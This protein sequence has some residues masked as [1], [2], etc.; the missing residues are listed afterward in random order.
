MSSGK[1]QTIAISHVTSGSVFC[2]Y[3]MEGTSDAGSLG[4]RGWSGRH[5][6]KTSTLLLD[7]ARLTFIASRMSQVQHATCHAAT[8]GTHKTAAV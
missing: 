5:H 3:L 2:V 4:T 8:A 6:Q 1:L 7:R